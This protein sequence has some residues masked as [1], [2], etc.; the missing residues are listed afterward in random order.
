M[1]YEAHVELKWPGE[2]VRSMETKLAK[3]EDVTN[4]DIVEYASK[5]SS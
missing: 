5:C 4:D 1:D 3:L 2:K